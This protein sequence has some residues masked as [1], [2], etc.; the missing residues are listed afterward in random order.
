MDT[1]EILRLRS[2]DLLARLGSTPFGLASAEAQT[3]LSI[4]G[5]NEI[6]RKKKRATIVNFLMHFKNP[7]VLILM[8][9]VFVSAVLGDVLDATI[10]TNIVLISVLMDFI[11][12]SRAEEA[13][14]ELRNKVAITATVLRDGTKQNI[15]FSE[16]VPGDVIYLSA[17]DVVPADSRLLSAKDLF[18]DQAALTGESF[19]VEKT[20]ERLT[21]ITLPAMTEW[22]N[23]LFM[24][25][26]ILSGTATAVVVKTGAST[27]YGKIA[28][29]L[30]ERRPETEFERGLRR[31]GF[32]IM[33]I[34]FALVIFVFFINALRKRDILES[35]LFSV[36]LAVGL[37]PE[38]LPMIISVN[39]SKGAISMSRKGVIVK[40]LASIQNLGSMDVL[41]TD[42]TG[43]LTQGRV[44]L[45]SHIDFQGNETDKIATF[46]YLNSYFETGLKSPVDESIL[47]QRIETKEYHKIDEIPFDF[48]RKRLSVIVGKGPER[49]LITKGAP[50]NV[51]LTCTQFEIG[52]VIK[53]LTPDILE[54]IEQ[55]F[56][57]LS[58]DGFRTLGLSYKRLLDD[59]TTYSVDDESSMIFLGFVMFFDPPKETA[60]ES[61]HLL[62]H[63]G[64][65]VKVIT[66]DNELVAKN[67]CNQLGFEIKG[68]ALGSD[69][70]KTTQEALARVVEKT[71]IFA[72]VTPAQKDRIIMALRSNGHTVGF[73]GDGINDAPCMRAADVS[74]SVDNA[75]DVAKESADIILL[76]PDLHILAEGVLEGRKTFG[77]TMKYVMMGISSNFGN[78]FSV[79]SASMFLPFLPML[80]TQILLNNLMYDISETTIPTDNVDREYIEKPRK[81]DISFIRNFMI[82]FGLTSSLFDFITFFVMIRIFRADQSLFQTAW[83]MESLCTQTLVILM[84]RTRRSPFYKSYPSKLLLFSTLAIASIALVLPFTPLSS[85]FKFTVPPTMFL[86]IL[87]LLV[88]YYLLLVEFLKF[89]F[90]KKS[91]PQRS[92]PLAVR[93]V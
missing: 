5:T 25:T 89:W 73:L 63:A 72:R 27:E 76:R 3:R 74:L 85:L 51:L 50:E 19:P 91:S 64:V 93:Q 13:A 84:I 35:L 15:K 40:R 47:H 32:L 66:G 41:C 52:E 22:D 39:L 61:L 83:F 20:Y 60:K 12:E 11:Q 10:I 24:G 37:T 92:P 70:E 54:K 81:I 67:V 43:T 6:A 71:S 23:Y 36:A 65:E 33:Q 80:P 87:A 2:D 4:Y 53:S 48:N 14:E 75:V 88:G 68:T 90:Y 56:Y 77:N 38:L 26:S 18:V 86:V 9:A 62:G 58:S 16:I 34:T 82:V 31:F 44:V 55:K 8:I 17:G 69:I 7:L 45:G 57:Q 30:V 49:F 79:A 21:F 46:C 28:K 1:E 42:K 29:R 78:M 59:K